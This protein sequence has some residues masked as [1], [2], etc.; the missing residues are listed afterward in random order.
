MQSQSSGEYPPWWNELRV[1]IHAVLRAPK[2]VVDE[3]GAKPPYAYD[4]AKK[5]LVVTLPRGRT[6]FRLSAGW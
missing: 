1:V 2:A 4:V 5:T 3:S 6:D